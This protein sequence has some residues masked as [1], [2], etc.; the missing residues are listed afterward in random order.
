MPFAFQQIDVERRGNVHC[1]RL[2]KPQLNEADQLRLGEELAQ[3]IDEEDCRRLALSLGNDQLDCLY[4]MF[5]GK[6]VGTRRTIQE[7]GG[8]MHLA[9]V[10]PAS[11]GVLKTCRL[12][13]LFEIHPTMD[14]AV[15]S[16]ET[17]D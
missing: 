13:D 9:E 4:S 1:V 16:L 17:L 6:L 14:D 2:K 8:H 5:L 10:G 11:Y 3:L 7:Q 15:K 12:T